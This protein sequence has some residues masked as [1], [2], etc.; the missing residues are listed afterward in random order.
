MQQ[1]K[2]ETRGLSSAGLSG[3][4]KIAA[5]EDHGDRLLLNGGGLGVALLGYRAQQLGAQAEAFKG[6]ADGNLLNSAWEGILP[7]GSGRGVIGD[8]NRMTREGAH[9]STS[10]ATQHASP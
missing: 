5:R 1:R 6:R 8:A 10:C 3:T 9:H 4:Q 2:R 7:T